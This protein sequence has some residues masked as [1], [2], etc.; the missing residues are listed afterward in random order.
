MKKFLSTLVA[1]VLMITVIQAQSLQ[2]GVNDLYAERFKSARETF[3]KLTAANPNNIEA[4]YWLG[5][6]Y[7]AQNDIAGARN[8]YSKA[9]MASANAPLLIVGMGHVEVLENKQSDARQ[10]FEAAITMTRG[11]KGDDPEILNAVGRAIVNSYSEKEKKG[12]IN[13][14]VEKLE[15]AAAR[16]DKNAEIYL[17]LGNAY[18]KAKPGEGGGRAFEMYKKA[19]SIN[20]NFAPPYHRLAHLFNSQRNYDLYEQYLNDAVSKDPRYAP[21]YYDLYYLK[22]GKLDFAAA[23]DMASKLI[24]NSDPDPQADHFKAQTLW[25]EKKYDEAIALSKSIIA[26]AGA[27]T[28]PRSYILLADAYLSKGDTAS[29]KQYIDEYFAKAKPE[30]ISAVHYR[31][32]ADIYSAIPGQ[33]DVVFNSY[34]EGLKADTVLENKLDLLK[35]GTAFFKARKQ[36]DKESQ[37]HQLIAELKPD[38]SL[39]DLFNATLANYFATNYSVSRDLALKMQEKFPAEQYGYEWA[40]NNARAVDTVKKDSIGLPDALKLFEFAQKDSIKFKRQYISA[41]GY[42]VNYYANDAKDY[43]KALDYVNRWIS[44][45]P[46]N[47]S[48][49]TIKDQL[50][51]ARS[52]P[53]NPRSAPQPSKSGSTGATKTK[54]KNSG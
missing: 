32:K 47:S 38:L 45:D 52:R 1:S 34:L 42:L 39:T 41:A 33:E 20:P 2:D 37:L 25:A 15:A 24:A 22:L 5:Q 43:T 48:L 51:K 27:E 49:P 17:N 26:K 7:I 44:L 54:D 35:K 23:Q 4:T 46:S 30:D 53:S 11:K 14:A 6:T 13:Y 50:E 18:R 31:I 9:L 16:D 12:D 8:V 29:G 21:A 10:R 3:E 19:N 28:K 40:F 36:Y